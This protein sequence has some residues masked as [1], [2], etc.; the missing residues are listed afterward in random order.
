MHAVH[1]MFQR[2]QYARH[3][4][5]ELE[6][7]EPGKAR[8]RMSVLP[9]HLNGV[10]TVQGGALFTLADFAFAAASNSHG[11]IAVA[12]NVSITFMKAVSSGT[13]T[14]AAEEVAINP[15]LGAYTVRIT[16]ESGAL[17]AIFQGLAYR[18]KDPVPH[19]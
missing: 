4:G 10:G 17:V 8:A 19:A 5:I 15:R 2:D 1:Q 16:D 3:S 9:C 6:S 14:A 11:T 18:K 7:V 13:L 12:I